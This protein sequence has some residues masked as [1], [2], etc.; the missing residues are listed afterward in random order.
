[1]SPQADAD[2]FGPAELAACLADAPP[3]LGQNVSRETLEALEVY[4]AALRVWDRTHNLVG[5]REGARLWRRHILD[6]VQLAA[7]A[8]V[9][10]VAE[11]RW[12]D[13]G[14]GAGVPGLLAAIALRERANLRFILVE[15]TQKRAAFLR[16][17]IRRTG[18]RAEV[19]AERVEALPPQGAAVISARA[20]AELTDLLALAHPHLGPP[21]TALEGE[22][23]WIKGR[24]AAAEL[25]RARESWTF[26]AHALPGLSGDGVI[27]HMKGLSPCRTPPPVT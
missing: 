1:M 7:F 13:I 24:D 22:M 10:Q 2:G 8:P 9:E 25:T 21:S 5:P 12:L 14:T 18:A 23:L 11:Q 19:I 17:V 26:T 16:D 6:G 20:V 3:P 27:V 15:P 4:A